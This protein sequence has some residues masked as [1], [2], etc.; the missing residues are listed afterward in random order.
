M[1]CFPSE[2]APIAPHRTGPKNRLDRV[3]DAGEFIV[4]GSFKHLCTLTMTYTLSELSGVHVAHMA[5]LAPRPY[6][7]STLSGIHTAL[8]PAHGSRTPR[9]ALAHKT[10]TPKKEE[11]NTSAAL[12]PRYYPAS[13]VGLWVNSDQK[14]DRRA[15]CDPPVKGL[16]SSPRF[17]TRGMEGHGEARR[18]NLRHLTFVSVL[19]FLRRFRALFTSYQTKIAAVHLASERLCLN[20]AG[21]EPYLHPPRDTSQQSTSRLHLCLKHSTR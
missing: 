20:T 3:Q 13:A 7:A 21:T 17:L 6:T 4:A 8:P 10:H 15:E 14:P 16:P 11:N 1:H 9:S 5:I 18:A 12:T 2:T 19:R